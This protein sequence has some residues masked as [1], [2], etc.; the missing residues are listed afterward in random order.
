MQKINDESITCKII[1]K[2]QGNN[3]NSNSK[4]GMFMAQD[5]VQDMPQFIFAKTTAKTMGIAVA[6]T[7]MVK[8]YHHYC[9]GVGKNLNSKI[10]QK[11][12]SP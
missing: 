4:M 9:G 11:Y 5:I 1:I 7:K 6:T 12:K 10:F 8:V 2:Q 3:S